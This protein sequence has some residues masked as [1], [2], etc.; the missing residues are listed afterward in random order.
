M[1]HIGREPNPRNVIIKNTGFLAFSRTLS[2]ILP[3]VSIILIGR[4]L[5]SQGVGMIYG[6]LALVLLFYQFSDFGYS[7]IVVREISRNPEKADEVLQKGFGFIVVVS[8]FFLVLLYFSGFLIK[9]F[10]PMIVF[11]LGS[12]FIIS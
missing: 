5:G 7:Q 3:A 8:L 11:I 9:K 10:P 6:I 2:S 1:K 12:S 4:A